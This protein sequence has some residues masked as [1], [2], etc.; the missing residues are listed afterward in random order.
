MTQEEFESK[1][2][3]KII[4]SDA[5]S[6]LKEIPD[7][8]INCCITSP[9]YWGLRDYK[10]KEQIGLEKTPE[11]Y[12]SKLTNIF[13]EVK[14]ILKKDGTLWLNLGDS[15]AGGGR[16]CNTPKQRSNKGTQ[17][18]PDS[19]VPAGLKTKDLCGIPWR[20]A[21]ALQEKGWWLRQD[22][23]WSKPDPMP[24]SVTDRCTKSH[25]YLFLLSKSAKYYYDHEAIKE[26]SVDDESYKGRKFRGRKQI[27]D[28]DV[29]PNKG[30]GIHAFDRIEIGQLYEKRNRRSVWTISVDT[31]NGIHFAVF[32]EQLIEPCIL[33]GC[34]EGGITID[35]FMGSG[36]VA[37]VAAKNRRN[38][39][40][41]ELNPKFVE[42]ARQKAT[43][44][45]V[46][47]SFKEL[48]Q[49][50]IPLFPCAKQE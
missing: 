29:L 47:V 48:Q 2:V 32:P 45:E 22:I 44:G 6:T 1:Y 26:D 21:F 16:G 9:P 11:E 15:Y 40:G 23:I 28:A 34:P 7:E 30:N 43:E 25:E 12:V 46:G 37:K 10:V 31:G 33:A 4:C 36:T 14:R 27:L 38:Y 35:V 50:Q 41:I 39:I 24:E 8:C 42:I 20:V 49:G 3:N 17:D 13:E 5:L 18:M 19:I